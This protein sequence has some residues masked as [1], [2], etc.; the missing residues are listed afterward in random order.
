MIV[1]SR[2]YCHNACN[3]FI[4]LDFFGNSEFAEEILA[5]FYKKEDLQKKLALIEKYHQNIVDNISNFKIEHQNF[6]IKRVLSLEIPHNDN[7]KI[8]M[9]RIYYYTKRINYHLFKAY[10]LENVLK[11]SIKHIYKHLNKFIEHNYVK[12]DSQLRGRFKF[13]DSGLE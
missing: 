6:K 8:H 11:I 7:W 4:L 1:H 13:T 3:G 10:D 2:V 9:L 5:G 12:K